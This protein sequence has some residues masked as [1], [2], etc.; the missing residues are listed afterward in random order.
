MYVDPKAQLNRGLFYLVIGACIASS[1]YAIF[2][3]ENDSDDYLGHLHMFINGLFY[4]M[5]GVVAIHTTVLRDKIF[6]VN[7]CPHCNNKTWNVA[8]RLKMNPNV[9]SSCKCSECKK[10]IKWKYSPLIFSLIGLGIFLFAVAVA[11]NTNFLFVMFDIYLFFLVGFFV[12]F[13]PLGVQ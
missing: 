6:G 8:R 7:K 4:L 2:I 1:L 11:Y 10:F 9:A 13:T 3:K 5:L 12:R